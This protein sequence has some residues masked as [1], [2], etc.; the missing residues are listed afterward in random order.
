MDNQ[1][2]LLAV[3]L[4]LAILLGYNYFIIP[5]TVPPAG[6]QDGGNE[7]VQ[8]AP[9]ASSTPVFAPGVMSAAPVSAPIVD[10][11]SGR[12]GRDIYVETSLY[13][14]VITENG[15]GVKSFKLK[16]YNEHLD[17]AEGFKELNNQTKLNE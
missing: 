2:V 8:V 10:V 14:A 9:D 1:R 17:P 3:V 7:T 12:E 4:S 13:Q 16:K 11:T 6:L 15:G 5:H